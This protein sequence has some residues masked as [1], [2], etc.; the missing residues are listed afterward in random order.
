MRSGATSGAME[1]TW[2][3]NSAKN[4]DVATQQKNAEHRKERKQLR[5]AAGHLS[6]GR[7]FV[8]PKYWTKSK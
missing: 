8:D 3:L 2:K 5:R 1:M 4:S 7:K 6:K